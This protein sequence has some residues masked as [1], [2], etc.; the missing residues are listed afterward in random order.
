MACQTLTSAID[1]LVQR[2]GLE[3]YP[4]GTGSRHR[5]SWR[6]HE[7]LHDDGSTG[8]HTE[9]FDDLMESRPSAW[10][11]ETSWSPEA[12]QLKKLAVKES[13]NLKHSFKYSAFKTL[14]IVDKG[15]SVVDEGLLKFNCLEELV[16]SANNIT[17]VPSENLPKTLR[18]LELFSNKISSLKNLTTHPP[19]H[20]HHLG[21]GNNCLG[22]PED[23]QYLTAHHWPQLMS[24]DLSWCG[25]KEQYALVDALSRLPR[26]RS[27]VLQGNPLTLTTLYPGFTVDSLERLLYLDEARVTSDDRCRFSGLAN[28]KASIREEAE[29]TVAVEKMTGVPDP[30][31]LMD[32]DAPEFPLISHG[33]SVCYEFLSQAPSLENI[34][35]ETQTLANVPQN[36]E[37]HEEV[38]SAPCSSADLLETCYKNQNQDFNAP[39]EKIN[40][41]KHEWAEVIEFNYKKTHRINNLDALKSFLLK[42]LWLT[43]E[44]E[45]VLSWPAQSAEG[46][47]TKA[48]AQKKGKEQS[49]KPKDKMNKQS[50]LDL[51][52]DPPVKRIL[53]SVHVELKSLLEVKDQIQVRCDLGTMH[54]EQ[55]IGKP[56]IQDKGQNKKLKDDRKEEKKG[57]PGGDT[58]AG[59]TNATSSKGR[60]KGRNEEGTGALADESVPSKMEPLTVEFSV[61]LGKRTSDSQASE[62]MGSSK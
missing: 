16:L 47:E 54:L 12:S 44:E 51:I 10:Y 50:V 27:L 36:P 13:A 39:V 35:A 18:V 19:P 56:F 43:V 42:G 6:A 58:A 8:A 23:L 21:L 22:Q 25:F 2:Q 9:D 7:H 33:Y 37:E 32:D 57:K 53:G 34:D 48:S 59:Q 46:T 24:L 17:D 62:C 1:K 52:H 45:K 31:S 49:G 20:L 40:T 3:S 60:D 55:T 38:T 28:L 4:C 15:V 14:R 41:L 26:L 11:E 30:A 61:R 5:S 29:I